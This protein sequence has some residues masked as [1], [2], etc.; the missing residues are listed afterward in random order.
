MNPGEGNFF[1]IPENLPGDFE[2]FQSIISNENILV[3]RIISTGQFTPENQWL[4]QEKNEWVIVLNGEAEIQI[5][6]EPVRK[7]LAGDYL[8]IPGN[9]R[10]RVVS[11]SSS[12]EC[13]WLAIHY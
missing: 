11:T 13:V 3:E 5:E 6:S 4:E 8:L 10:H 7:M 12:P 2:L 9:T 1:K